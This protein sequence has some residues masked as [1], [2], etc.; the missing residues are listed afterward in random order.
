L[1]S[2]EG[3]T[4]LVIRWSSKHDPNAS[5]AL[6]DDECW[7][8]FDHNFWLERRVKRAETVE[9]EEEIYDAM[10]SRTKKEKNECQ[11]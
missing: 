1:E 2:L 7:E 4:A 11:H 10:L 3:K 9:E 5:I 6:C 8:I